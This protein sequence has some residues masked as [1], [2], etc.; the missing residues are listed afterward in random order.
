L[1]ASLDVYYQESGR[2]GRDGN[3]ADCTLLFQRRDRRLQTFFM[4]GRYP[5]HDDFATLIA[6]LRSIDT[7]RA[8]TLT[9]LRDAAPAIGVAKLRVMLT[10]L[11]QEGRIRERRGA[12][13]EVRQQ[14]FTEPVEEFAR[15]YEE[16]RER[17]LSKLEQMIVYAQTSL[18]RTQLMLKALGEDVAWSAC[19]TC[20]NCRGEAVRAAAS[21]AG[22]A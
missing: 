17:D 8:L 10:V 20:D 1:P 13:Y 6:G 5:T 16:R 2:A 18:C 22:A 7:A 4:A 11:K 19:G 14:L 12:G 9:E 21:A 15:H 3:P